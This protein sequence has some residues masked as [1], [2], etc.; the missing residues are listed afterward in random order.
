ME[1]FINR[2]LHGNARDLLRALP[3]ESIDAVITDPMYG[4]PLVY[5]WGPDPGD[6]WTNHEPIYKE[7]RRVLKPGGALAWSIAFRNW[8]Q[9]RNWFS[10]HR[11]WTLVR[12]FGRYTVTTWI[13]QTR[14]QQ[15]IRFPD[16][17]A[18]I[19]HRRSRVPPPHPCPK[20][21]EEML[22][23]VESLTQPGQ[24]VLD[25]FCGLGSTLIAAKKLGRRYIGCDISRYYCQVAMRRLDLV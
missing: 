14:E 18:C 20:T 9:F 23:I 13:V 19:V 15:P 1:R 2:V 21:V 16:R 10:D 7:C 25:C 11:L 3:S 8:R 24:L 22:L 12:F 4:L 17:D 6:Y 5:D